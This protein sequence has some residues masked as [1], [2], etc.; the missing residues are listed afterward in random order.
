VWFRAAPASSDVAALA[1]GLTKATQQT[2]EGAD[3]CLQERLRKSHSPNNEAEELGAI[4]GEDLGRWPEDL[5]LVIDDYHHLT[6]EPA[7]ERFIDAFGTA[8]DIPLLITSR[9]R[10]AWA[11][12]RRLL[13]GEIAEF[14]RNV[15][16]MTHDEAAQAVSLVD[17][18]RSLAGLVALA[19]GWPAV[20]GL[21]SLVQSSALNLEHEIPEA[22]HS[23][24]ADELYQEID[25]ELQKG[26]LELSLAPSIDAGLAAMLFGNRATAALEQYIERGFL[27]REGD[28][29]EIHPLVRQ[30]LR[31]KLT[32]EDRPA[33]GEIA[34]A[35]GA[36][37]LQR[38]RWDEAFALVKEFGLS[39]LLKDLLTRGLDE[40]LKEG[41]IA[42]LEQWIETAHRLIPSEDILLLA[43]VELAFR[44][45]RWREAE[46][47][48]RHLAGR[49][50][51]QHPL[52]SRALFRAAEVAHLDD[53]QEE[54]LDLLDEARARSTAS[55][56]LRR[57]I[58]TTFITLTDLEE[59]VRAAS[60]LDE[61]ASLPPGSVDDMIRISQGRIHFAVRWGGVRE[62]LELHRPDLQ[63]LER[64]I[65]PVVRSGFLQSWGTALTLTARYEEAREVADRQ[66][67][68]AQR[69]GLD[70]VGPHALELRGLTQ[71]G[72]RDFS[73]AQKSL[74][75]ALRAAEEAHDLHAQL[76]ALALLARIPLVQ[77]KPE[78]A[79][80][81][82]ETRKRAPG[83]GMEGELTSIRALALAC[84]DRLDD[85]LAEIAASAAITSH[86]EARGLR[87]YADVVVAHAQGET[88][89]FI[90][91]LS[92][93]IQQSAETGNA[94]AFVCAYRAY[95]RLLPLI[96]EADVP[97]DEFLLRPLKSYDP[98]L[99]ER[100]GLLPKTAHVPG[101]EALT[102]REEEVLSL[103][104]KGLSNR[105]IA[106]A[107]WIAESTVKAHI[108]HIFEKL[109]V[110]SRTEAALFQSEERT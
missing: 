103:L 27:N 88:D 102:E 64:T 3:R 108:R 65:D 77:G 31:S 74:H 43:E 105:E 52:A 95:P 9:V 110:R 83:P 36:F 5:W 100:S 55:A 18:Q 42:T 98:K 44:R 32:R 51:S 63:L 28:T 59:P 24:L 70:W 40:L 58:W 21:A 104:Q 90:M 109:G 20:I 12:A 99:A 79:L 75:A 19:E 22:L 106:R 49:V 84:V 16:A 78:R 96:A 45:G 71:I 34:Q 67:H 80:D 60:A 97:L 57:A 11:S 13:Y 8:G 68:D 54:A 10:P 39:D 33:M 50:D 35:I 23:Y 14:G 62:Q 6:T 107:L 47:K 26:L 1:L 69:F 30:F 4:L 93:A 66:L 73:G 81:L 61:F 25:E 76:N 89:N 29:Y 72:M 38:S 37:C 48:A 85:A 53:R 101:R 17:K 46:D 92:S 2:I 7:A 56:D 87:S 94:D 91:R 41:R 86:L 82:L 15:L